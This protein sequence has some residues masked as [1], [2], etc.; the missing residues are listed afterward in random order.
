MSMMRAA[1]IGGFVLMTGTGTGCA[2]AQMPVP[3][4]LAASERMTVSG[5][6]GLRI[7]QRVRFGSFEAHDV[8]RSWTR[9]S[10]RGGESATR[11]TRVQ[12]YRFNVRSGQ[13]DRWFVSCRHEVEVMTVRTSVVDLSPVDRSALYCNLHPLTG[14]APEDAWEMELRETRDRPLSGSLRGRTDTLSV[15]G[16]NR[17]DRALA[18]AETTGFEIRDD[19][20]AL[21]AVQVLNKGAVWLPSDPAPVRRDVLAA[22]AAALLLMDELKDGID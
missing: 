17:V 12:E 22:A 11:S 1:A 14:E 8:K 5:R 15:S 13:E 10:D 7:N 21:A 4:S 9:G 19:E 20:R 16:T 6:Q 2:L 18:M 3:E